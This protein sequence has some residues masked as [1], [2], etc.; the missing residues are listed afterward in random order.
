[1]RRA[2]IG[3]HVGAKAGPP[4]RGPALVGLATSLFLRLKLL[5]ER[6]EL[7]GNGG[8]EGVVLLLEALPNR[9]EHNASV[10][11]R[12]VLVL[13]L[14]GMAAVEQMPTDPIV[15]AV[16]CLSCGGDG[17]HGG[18]LPSTAGPPR[19]KANDRLTLE[20]NYQSKD[21]KSDRSSERRGGK[22]LAT[23]PPPAPR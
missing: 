13:V 9:G 7:Q 15:E 20:L 3:A 5:D 6:S 18:R 10:P 2:A 14:T 23:Y 11:G 8:R 12:F 17:R 22:G 4:Q 19:S 1:M 21:V 16:C